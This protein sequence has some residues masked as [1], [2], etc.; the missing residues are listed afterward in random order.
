M[1]IQ[2]LVLAC[3]AQFA[4][5]SFFIPIFPACFS[6]CDFW[7]I[8]AIFV[9]L[10][11]TLPCPTRCLYMIAAT[12]QQ[13]T[14]PQTTRPRC[15]LDSTNFHNSCVCICVQTMFLYAVHA[16][17]DILKSYSSRFCI[18]TQHPG[19]VLRM[20]VHRSEPC[21][22]LCVVPRACTDTIPLSPNENPT[23]KIAPV[24]DE[25]SA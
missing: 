22:I 24:K 5:F 20:N 13:K 17:I 18:Q 19:I 23:R 2:R 12:M 8:N 9:V 14:Q 11:H 15:A 16:V 7:M 25:T 1:R 21:S 4:K 10:C 6:V 3:L